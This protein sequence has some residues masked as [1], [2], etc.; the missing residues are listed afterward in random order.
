M[1]SSDLVMVGSYNYGLVALSILIAMLG[2]YATIDPGKGLFNALTQVP[3]GNALQNRW[4][5]T[6][7]RPS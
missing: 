1:N 6:P 3:R 4:R 2:S 7:C 5:W